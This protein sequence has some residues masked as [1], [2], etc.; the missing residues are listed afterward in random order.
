MF[1]GRAQQQSG[2]T[3]K[4]ISKL[5]HKTVEIPNLTTERKKMTKKKKKKRLETQG[6]WNYNKDLPLSLESR[7]G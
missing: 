7:R 1:S 2:G 3:E 5:D 4:K 6:L